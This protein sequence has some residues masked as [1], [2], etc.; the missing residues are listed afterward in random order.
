MKILTTF[1][2]FI[3]KHRFIILSMIVVGAI[4]AIVE[5][6]SG[7]SL[8]G[9]DGHFGWWDNNIW[10]NETSQRV[11]DVYSFSHIIH[12][13]LFYGFLWFIWSKL[14]ARLQEK[15]PRKYWFLIA[16]LIEGGWELLENS[17]LIIDRYRT[18]TIALGYFGDSV[19]N[20]V[21]DVFMMALGFLVARF[22]KVWV[23][24]MLIIVFELGCLWWVR[25]NLT[26][27]VLQLVYPSQAIKEWQ[28]EGHN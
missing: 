2:T 11:A 25:D 8:L 24:I 23:V 4:V 13:M 10:G 5:I 27:N 20:S 18:A 12:G 19:L 15:F 16:L 28:A 21:S 3:K 14:P 1:L 26:L 17:P 7:R 6:S 22:S 9:P